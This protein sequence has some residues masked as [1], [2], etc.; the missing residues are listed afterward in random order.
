M[1]MLLFGVA[2]SKDVIS[3]DFIVRFENGYVDKFDSVNE[4]FTR[5]SCDTKALKAKVKLTEKEIGKLRV[6]ADSTGF[7]NF[8]KNQNPKINGT[9]EVKISICGPCASFSLGLTS[10]LKAN[11]VMWSCNCNRNVDPTP[12]SVE[13]IVSELRK[14]IYERVEVKSLGNSSCRRY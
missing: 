6:L 9:G 14:I 5:A 2:I 7:Y 1:T 10:K 4:S 12:K 8:E 11:T 3:D 13:P